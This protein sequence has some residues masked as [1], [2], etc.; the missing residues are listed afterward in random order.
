MRE[1]T[2]DGGSQLYQRHT[3]YSPGI[4]P[5]PHAR[6][7]GC[8][9]V[10]EDH[11][12]WLHSAARADTAKRFTVFKPHPKMPRTESQWML[13]IRGVVPQ[14]NVLSMS[15]S[16]AGTWFACRVGSTR[17]SAVSS[18]RSWIRIL[19]KQANTSGTLPPRQSPKILENSK[20]QQ[21][22]TPR[23]LEVREVL[24][25]STLA[26]PAVPTKKG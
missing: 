6:S 1:M 12:S 3:L 16:K 13:Y 10:Q 20:P 7:A 11:W 25:K 22:W 26:L 5:L 14:A 4:G 21:P 24:S 15:P 2:P 17:S 19:E 23:S 9:I 8:G 18:E